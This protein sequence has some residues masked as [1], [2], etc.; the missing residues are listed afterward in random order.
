VG[1]G[2]D[3]N[4]SIYPVTVKLQD[5]CDQ[6][7]SGMAADV[8]MS[9]TVRSATTEQLIALPMVSVGEDREGNFVFVLEPAGADEPGI[10]VARRRS[11]EI[12]IPESAA[13]PILS[14]IEL[15]EKVA[16]AGVRRLTDGQRVSLLAANPAT[17]D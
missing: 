3:Q 2:T 7:L 17:Q 6:V 13:M 5:G 9:L 8:T 11:V 16:T 15:G 14:G 10:Y 4:R 12:G 1:I